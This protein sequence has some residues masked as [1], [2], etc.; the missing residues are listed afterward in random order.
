[1]WKTH[2]LYIIQNANEGFPVA[3]PHL[4]VCCRDISWVFLRAKASPI[5]PGPM[6]MRHHSQVLNAEV[7]HG[8]HHR[9]LVGCCLE[10]WS[11]GSLL[12]Y[13]RSRY[14]CVYIYI[15]VYIWSPPA[16]DTKYT[17]IY[18]HTKVVANWSFYS[19]GACYTLPAWPRQR[20]GHADE[21]HDFS[22][23]IWSSDWNS[24]KSPQTDWWM[25]SENG[26]SQNPI[27][28]HQA[29]NRKT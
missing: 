27:V 9:L 18:T 5:R 6:G 24:C 1:M 16:G 4:F 26:V 25:G 13:S 7:W 3:F 23:D 2:H 8:P 11:G 15:Y 28:N 14:V 10:E 19:L 22:F 29:S 20:Q 12:G 21:N 17:N